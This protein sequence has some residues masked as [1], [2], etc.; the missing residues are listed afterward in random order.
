MTPRGYYLQRVLIH[1]DLHM[2]RRVR[3]F[4]QMQSSLSAGRLGGP[5][6]PTSWIF[7]R[8]SAI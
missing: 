8:H 6:T 4:T 7:T 3:V 5:R 2:G 1:A